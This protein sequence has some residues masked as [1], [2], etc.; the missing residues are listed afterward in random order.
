MLNLSKSEKYVILFLSISALLGMG[1]IRIRN[2]ASNRDFKI[3]Q[4]DLSDNK[5]TLG[6]SD[7]KININTGSLEEL[8]KL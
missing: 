3:S 2:Y 4:I 6:E 7:E 5:D 8:C 1:I